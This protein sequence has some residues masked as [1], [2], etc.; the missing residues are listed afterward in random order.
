MIYGQANSIKDGA[1]WV[2][3]AG[4]ANGSADVAINGTLKLV[5]LYFVVD[6]DLPGTVSVD[7]ENVQLLNFKGEEI[8]FIATGA[9]AKT[10]ALMDVD[11]NGVIDM[12]D[13]LAAYKLILDG[14]YNAAADIDKNGVIEAADLQAMYKYLIGAK[15]YAATRKTGI[16]AV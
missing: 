7:L 1:Q 9:E 3:V 2:T 8:G 12:A 4:N 16:A 10:V 13:I 11:K 15:T 6:Q 5:E 14:K